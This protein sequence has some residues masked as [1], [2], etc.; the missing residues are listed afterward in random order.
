MRAIACVP[1]GAHENEG[2]DVDDRVRRHDAPGR[3]HP[4]R[5]IREYPSADGSQRTHERGVSERR[6]SP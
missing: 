4:G 2:V 1:F 3:E 5:A 6:E